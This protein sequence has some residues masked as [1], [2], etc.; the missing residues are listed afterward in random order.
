MEINGNQW[1]SM[2]IN[3]QTLGYLDVPLSH[4]GGQAFS[5]HDHAEKQLWMENARYSRYQVSIR[6]G[7]ETPLTLLA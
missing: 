6:R 5:R 4:M 7:S 3:Q 2:E 1:K